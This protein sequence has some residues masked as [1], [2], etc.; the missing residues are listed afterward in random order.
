MMKQKAPMASG[1]LPAFAAVS[2][3]KCMCETV[4]AMKTIDNTPV[5]TLIQYSIRMTIR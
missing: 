1:A 3:W 5:T 4:R 2:T